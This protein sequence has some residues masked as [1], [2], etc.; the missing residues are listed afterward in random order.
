VILAS[1]AI[2]HPEISLD[3]YGPGDA[4]DPCLLDAAHALEPLL[5]DIT[6]TPTTRPWHYPLSF[7]VRDDHPLIMP[8][9]ANSSPLDIDA[10]QGGVPERRKPTRI[11]ASTLLVAGSSWQ[12]HSPWLCH[13]GR[14]TRGR[15]QAR[16]ILR[17]MAFKLWISRTSPR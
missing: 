13:G 17:S 1:A 2:A 14:R 7:S 9:D 11:N 15:A 4:L 16:Q 6:I 10:I 5:P 8:G 12:W 3:Q